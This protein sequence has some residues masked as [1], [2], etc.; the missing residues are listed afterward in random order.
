[1]SF[2]SE[3]TIVRHRLDND[4]EVGVVDPIE[5]PSYKVDHLLLRHVRPLTWAH[6]C[7]F[8]H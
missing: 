5:V 6:S 3:D 7:R 1:M 8:R 4:F 2:D